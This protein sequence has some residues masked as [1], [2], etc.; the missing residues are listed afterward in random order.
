VKFHYKIEAE[1]GRGWIGNVKT[2]LLDTTK[3]KRIA[4]REMLKEIG[5][6]AGDQDITAEKQTRKLIFSFSL[7]WLYHNP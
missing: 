5:C 6:L 3:L 7:L 2:M 1:G 4:T